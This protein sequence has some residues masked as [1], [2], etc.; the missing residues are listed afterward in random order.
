MTTAVLNRFPLALVDY[1]TWVDDDV[2]MVTSRDALSHPLDLSAYRDVAVVDDYMSARTCLILERLIH[3]HGCN[4]LVALSEFDLL[5]AA[6][7]RDANDMTGPTLAQTLPYRDKLLMKEVLHD[8]GIPVARFAPVNEFTELLAF[9]RDI[10]GPVV[11]KPRLG[12]SSIGVTVLRTG[13]DLEEYCRSV[14]ALKGDD[15]AYLLAEEFIDNEMFNI[16]GI[17]MNGAMHICWPSGTSSCLGFESGQLLI[18]SQLDTDDERVPVLQGLVRDTVAALPSHDRM[19]F[20]AEAFRSPDGHYLLNE[21]GARIGGA[22]VRELVSRGF[23]TDPVEWYVREAFGVGMSL[24]GL[25]DAPFR[26]HAYCLVPPRPGRVLEIDPTLFSSR[27]GLDSIELRVEVGDTLISPGSSIDGMAL[28]VTHGD[29]CQEAS[30][31]AE[32]VAEDIR[33]KVRVE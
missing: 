9:W 19:I 32:A 4:A 13:T 15:P 8:A 12:A 26:P 24:G 17:S 18:A 10:Q 21:I 11:V 5:R 33:A 16:D 27:D 23:G 20:H 28:V 30:S 29:S 14:G 31:V 7:L 6:R 1:P 22:K 3:Q 25:P 2:V